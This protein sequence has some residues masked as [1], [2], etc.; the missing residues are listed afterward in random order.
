MIWKRSRNINICWWKSKPRK[1]K[2]WARLLL[3]K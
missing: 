3:W 2:S 1:E